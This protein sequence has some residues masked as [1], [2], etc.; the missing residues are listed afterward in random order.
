MSCHVSHCFSNKPI[1]NCIYCTQVL[2]ITQIIDLRL[3]DFPMGVMK[4]V[5]RFRKKERIK[6]SYGRETE[7]GYFICCRVETTSRLNKLFNIECCEKVR[8]K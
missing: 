3:I 1:D 2:S 4:K 8:L 5:I 6:L 7:S